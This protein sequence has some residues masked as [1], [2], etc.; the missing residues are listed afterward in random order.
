MPGEDYP[1]NAEVPD[2]G[3]SCDGRV[4]SYTYKQRAAAVCLDPVVAICLEPNT[5]VALCLKPCVVS[6]C[7]DYTLLWPSV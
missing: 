5:A 7:L 6:V 3:F 4:S 2:T 1:V